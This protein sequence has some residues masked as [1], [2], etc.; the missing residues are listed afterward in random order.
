MFENR[1]R[2]IGEE[3]AEDKGSAGGI[4]LGEKGRRIRLAE[5]GALCAQVGDVLL[6]GHGRARFEYAVARGSG[7]TAN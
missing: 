2:D 4:L 7:S 3:F 5:R 6:A 1:L